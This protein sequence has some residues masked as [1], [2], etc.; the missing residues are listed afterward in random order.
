MSDKASPN[1]IHSRIWSEEPEQDDPY[2]TRAAYCSGYDVYGDVLGN[3]SWAQMIYLLFRAEAPT[4]QQARLLDTLAVALSNPGPRDASVHAAMCGGVCGS[5]A[6]SSLM[7]ALAV[8]A[9]QTSGAREVYW[10]MQGWAS[11]GTDCA[12]WRSWLSAP[13]ESDGSV[14]PE[15]DHPPGFEPRAARTSTPVLQTLRCLAGCGAGSRLDWLLDNLTPF[16]AVAARPLAMTG[17]AAAAL[18]DLGFTPEQGEMLY[19]MLRLPGAA[20][21]ALEQRPLGYKKF[22]FGTVELE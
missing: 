9:G 2:T 14:W 12:R 6:A 15:P 11:C 5:T 22:P 18:A 8:G 1:V 16:E 4:A 17:V 20:V 19:L 3:A 10:A 21:H 13:M 7:A